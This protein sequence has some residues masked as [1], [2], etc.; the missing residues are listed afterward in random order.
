MR[1]K[2]SL[3]RRI[4]LRGNRF[5]PELL[6]RSPLIT[7]GKFV[8]AFGATT[9]QDL[10]SVSRFH[11]GAESVLVG[12]F[13]SAGLERAFHEY[14]KFYKSALGGLDREVLPLPILWK[15]TK[16]KIIFSKLVQLFEHKIRIVVFARSNTVR[17]HK[18]HINSTVLRFDEAR[19]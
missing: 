16:N 1:A 19:L 7:N 18:F 13:S 14:L 2:A 12:T 10:T 8:T 17:N 6:L 3:P 15:D 11:A 9:C 5:P 4:N